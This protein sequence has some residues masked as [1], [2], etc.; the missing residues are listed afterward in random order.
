MPAIYNSAHGLRSNTEKQQQLGC[1][2]E[3]RHSRSGSWRGGRGQARP[4]S[5]RVRAPAP[6]TCTLRREPERLTTLSL[7]LC[8]HACMR[9]HRRTNERKHSGNQ[10][11]RTEGSQVGLRF[12]PHPPPL[13]VFNSPRQA[14]W[15]RGGRARAR[16]PRALAAAAPGKARGARASCYASEQ[17]QRDR[18]RMS[19]EAGRAIRRDGVMSEKGRGF[20]RS[21]ARPVL[22]PCWEG[23]CG[24]WSHL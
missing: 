11:A 5:G 21:G 18:A 7:S 19:V 17:G 16:Q 6:G 13:P 1:W 24:V 2:Y 3:G 10:R 15:S 22:C 4:A 14:L 9:A 20:P 23:A 12:L 8:V